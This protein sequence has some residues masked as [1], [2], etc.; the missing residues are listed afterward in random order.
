MT[1]SRYCCIAAFTLL[2]ACSTPSQR[3]DGMAQAEGLRKSTMEGSDFAHV[4]YENTKVG[5]A[6][7]LNVYLAGDGTPWIAGFII[8]SDPTPRRPIVLRLM[9]MDD[10]PS[11]MLGRPCYHGHA[12]HQ[13][14]TSDDWTSG[15]YSEVIVDSMARALRKV[16]A[17]HGH[18][19]LRLIGFSGGG[20]LAMLLA[21]R[22]PETETIV[23][24]AGNLD[25]DS[26]ADLHGYDPLEGSINPKLI[27][28]LP[29]TIRQ[30]HLAGGKDGNIPAEIIRGALINQPDSQYILFE[31]FTHACCWEEIWPSILACVADHCEW[32]RQSPK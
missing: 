7:S 20:G 30:Y 26:W 3:F 14:C 4:I 1:Y 5:S 11:L 28:P 32:S 17:Q 12:E 31:D 21:Q 29:A 22:L 13:P 9:A 16:M 15:R 27:A 6:P 23:T 10:S 19:K 25:I 2:A 24:I 18:T 8:A